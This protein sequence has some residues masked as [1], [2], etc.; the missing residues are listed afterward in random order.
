MVSVLAIQLRSAAGTL[1]WQWPEAQ[2]TPTQ[3]KL[4]PVRSVNPDTLV[5]PGGV[6]LAATADPG[7]VLDVPEGVQDLSAF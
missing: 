5:L 1:L 3:E 7:V 4:L 6:V 2:A